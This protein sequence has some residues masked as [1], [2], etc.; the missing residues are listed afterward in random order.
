MLTRTL[1]CEWSGHGIRVNAIAAGPT[2]GTASRAIERTPLGRVVSAQDVAET[3]AFLLSPDAGY[4]TGSVITVD[5][6]LSIHAGPDRA[7]AGY[8]T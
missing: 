7:V 2:E 1:A 8:V 4:V 6:G 5:G 3:A